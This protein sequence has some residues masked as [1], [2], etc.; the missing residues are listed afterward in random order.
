MPDHVPSPRKNVD[1][2]G[3]PVIALLIA[4]EDTKG[5]PVAAGNVSVFVPATA[6]ASTLTVTDA[7]GIVA[8]QQLRI[9]DLGK[10]EQVT[11]D[12]SY[13]YGSLTVPLTAPLLHTHAGGT[14]I[15]NLPTALKEA[16]ILI[17][18]AFIKVRG[19][20]S[21]TMAMTTAPTT[22]IGNATRYSGEIALALD[23]VNKYRRIR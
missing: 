6:G 12:A 3:V 18:T 23:M 17:T 16:C 15:G 11:V 7:T 9:Y 8:G 10:N 22:N 2:D 14:A 1:E 13:T 4:V 19:D 5:V 21:M 20:A